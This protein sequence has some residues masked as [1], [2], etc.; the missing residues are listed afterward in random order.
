MNTFPP[1]ESKETLFALVSPEGEAPRPSSPPKKTT[2]KICG[3]NYPLSIAFIV[4]NEFCERFSYYGMK[5]VLTLYF[6]YF[7]HWSEDTSTSVYH[8]FSSLCYFTPLLGAAMADSWLGKFRV[9]SMIGLFLIALGTGGIK[10]CV[11]AFGGDQFEAEHVN[12]RSKFFSV[13]YLSI[14]A[15]SLISMFVTPMLRGDVKCFGGDCYALA[16]G[17]PGML[18]VLALVVFVLGSK[19]YKKPP[20]E[21]NIVAQ[22]SKCIWFAISNRLKNRS[23]EIPKRNHWLDWAEEKY[24]KQLILDVK[25]LTRVL[26]LYI[27]L[28]MFWA[29]LDQQGSRWTLQA[30]RMNGN[31]GFFVFQPDQIQVLNPLLVLIFIPMFDLGIY[32]LI[33]KCGINLTSIKKMAAGM[34]LASLAF[35]VAAAVEIKINELAPHSPGGKE[36]Y[37]RILNL[38]DDEM[39]VELMDYQNKSLFPE[40]IKPFQQTKGHS[41]MLLTTES[42]SFHIQLLYH[43]MSIINEHV[44]KEKNKYTLVIHGKQSG[45]SSI[46][47]QDAVTSTANGMAAVRFINTMDKDINLTLNRGVSISVGQNYGISSYKI[48]ERGQYNGVLCRMGDKEFFLDLGLLDFGAAYVFVITDS[49][50]QGLRAWKTEDIS[51]NKMSLAWQLPQYIIVTASEVV[52]S[53]TGLEFSYSQA[54]PSM[55]SVLQAAWLLTVAIGNIIVL[56]VA[57]TSALVQWAEFILFSGLLLVICLIFSIMGYYYIPVKPDAYSSEDTMTSSHI[58]GDTKDLVT[59]KTKL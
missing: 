20:P 19:M 55:K 1:K 54:P 59:K 51:P 56:V 6:L 57:Q 8:A 3:S 22:V 38:A 7:L 50:D 48:L 32:P 39:K 15:G 46:L 12:E 31:M 25:A 18:M 24:P 44:M 34:I 23:R 4:V 33:K 9:L 42:Q 40:P 58:E 53:I 37:L 43:N 35:A 21:G 27:P 28:P 13:F 26:F 41:K 16:F 52:F 17:V 5:A 30:T 11:A 36:V 47:M 10:P 2:L 45:V 49:S 29:L 14:N